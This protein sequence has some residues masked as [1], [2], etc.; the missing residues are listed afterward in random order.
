MRKKVENG[1]KLKENEWKAERKER[2]WR[3]HAMGKGRTSV[4]IKVYKR[5]RYFVYVCKN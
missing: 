3:D 1:G 4:R 2:K 5:N